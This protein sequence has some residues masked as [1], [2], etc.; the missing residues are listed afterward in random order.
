[1]RGRGTVVRRT[2]LDEG[3][4]DVV[5]EVDRYDERVKKLSRLSH[6]VASERGHV[7]R[8]VAKPI[9]ADPLQY[10]LRVQL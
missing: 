2:T 9:P 7:R 4:E 1:M 3:G 10:C 8:K 5:V 6:H